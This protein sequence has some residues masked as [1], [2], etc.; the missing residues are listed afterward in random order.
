MKVCNIMPESL[1]SYHGDKTDYH[2]VIA[3]YIKKES[4][5][6]NFFKQRSNNGDYVIID[7]G[8]IEYGHPMHFKEV[9]ELAQKI[10]ANEIMLPDYSFNAERTFNEIV[11]QY[12]DVKDDY[13]L[14]QFNLIAVPQGGTVSE[15]LY[16]L[17][18][19]TNL[20]FVDTIGL[21]Y[22][23]DRYPNVDRTFIVGLMNEI[24]LVD[25]NKEYHLLG[26]LGHED[27]DPIKIQNISYYRWIRG[28]DTRTP[29]IYAYNG[30]Q[31]KPNKL[32]PKNEPEMFEE[33]HP[34]NPHNDLYEYNIEVFKEWCNYE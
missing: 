1:L 30:Y 14:D 16:C 20:D 22:L 29:I 2:L 25:K 27:M 3:P 7:N 26:Y 10:N 12:N 19:I 17:E 9:I 5:Y 28:I 34:E 6:M 33:I 24:G 32:R 8:V 15:Y 13:D 23:V 31:L 21:T 11:N 4:Y 18:R